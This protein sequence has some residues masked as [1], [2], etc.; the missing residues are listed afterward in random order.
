MIDYLQLSVAAMTALCAIGLLGDRVLPP[1]V[2]VWLW[3]ACLGRGLFLTQI[4]FHKKGVSKESVLLTSLSQSTL[5]QAAAPLPWWARWHTSQWLV[6][7]WVAGAAAFLGVMLVLQL[8]LR[9][10]LKVSAQ[11]APAALGDILRNA[12]ELQGRKRL[13]QL[14]ISPS[15][16]APFVV[17]FVRPCIVVP[18]IMVETFSLQEMRLV[19][20][21]ELQH[22]RSWD[23]FWNAAATFALCVQWFN[24]AAWLASIRLGAAQERAVDSAVLKNF[25]VRRSL[26]ANTLLRALENSIHSSAPVFMSS[27]VG[28]EKLVKRR[29]RML[30]VTWKWDIRSCFTVAAT[31]FASMTTLGWS[32]VAVSEEGAESQQITVHLKLTKANNGNRIFDQEST[33]CSSESEFSWD[34]AVSKFS[35]SGDTNSAIGHRIYIKSAYLGKNQVSNSL[36]LA[37]IRMS[38]NSEEITAT[39]RMTG[40]LGETMTLSES[41]DKGQSLQI[42]IRNTLGCASSAK[43]KSYSTKGCDVKIPSGNKLSDVIKSFASCLEQNVRMSKDATS[44]K[45][46]SD[47]SFR[48]SPEEFK[49]SVEQLLASHQMKMEE[50]NLPDGGKILDI[51]R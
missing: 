38:D 35:V 31:A 24:P 22:L 34:Y 16:P 30:F 44:E 45:L 12:C 11:P 41:N 47:F 19:L 6:F 9:A 32:V 4:V 15:F 1:R 17:G 21:H 23:G 50:R 14:V 29:I 33:F 18:K 40:V 5:P 26:Y 51:F 25:G 7:V 39:P 46:G 13:P 20:L 10:R 49:N 2:A 3:L 27:L 42:Q 28:G 37:D 8:R 48:G 43:D 36:R